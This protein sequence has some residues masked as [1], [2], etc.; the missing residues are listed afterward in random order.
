MDS[1]LVLLPRHVE[2]CKIK[3]RAKKEKISSDMTVGSVQKRDVMKEKVCVSK[4]QK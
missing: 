1:T 3:Y 4:R 2:C